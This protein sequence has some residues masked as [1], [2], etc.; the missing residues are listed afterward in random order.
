MQKKNSKVRDYQGGGMAILNR[1]IRVCFIEKITF[2]QR[3][4]IE[5]NMRPLDI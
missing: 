5:K 4:G 3:F 2:E 1:V